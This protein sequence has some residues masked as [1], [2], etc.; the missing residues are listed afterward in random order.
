MKLLEL[1]NVF[2]DNNR[3]KNI[4]WSYGDIYDDV[5]KLSINQRFNILQFNLNYSKKVITHFSLDDWSEFRKIHLIQNALYDFIKA[6]II[7]KSWNIHIVDKKNT[8]ISLGSTNV[9]NI[10]KFNT[11][12]INI[13]PICFHGTTTRY[14]PD[15]KKYGLR[16]RIKTNVDQNWDSYYIED[17]D[18][19]IYLTFDFERASYYANHALNRDDDYYHDMGMMNKSKAIVLEIRN[20]DTNGIAS[21]DDFQGH[22]EQASNIMS[23]LNYLQTGKTNNPKNYIASMRQT[24]QFAYLYNIPYNKIFKIHKI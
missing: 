17:S 2:I 21:D 7:D 5:N 13:I 20:L 23:L 3:P 4:F 18:K 1:K 8:K 6:K 24:G 22:N 19:K 12:F 11:D 10:I 9:W 16:P 15:I 14:L